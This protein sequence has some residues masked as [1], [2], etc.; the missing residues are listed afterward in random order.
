MNYQ[1]FCE[2]AAD[3]SIAAA[4]KMAVCNGV[5]LAQAQLWALSFSKG[6]PK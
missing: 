3:I 5:T 2:W 6:E 4:V 1:R